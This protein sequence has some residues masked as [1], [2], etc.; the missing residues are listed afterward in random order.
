MLCEKVFECYVR[1]N[2]STR[3]RITKGACVQHH[4]HPRGACA[5]DATKMLQ[6]CYKG[7]TRVLQGCYKNVTRCYKVDHLLDTDFVVAIHLQEHLTHELLY[8]RLIHLLLQCL[9]SGVGRQQ[10]QR[11]V[12]SFV[13]TDQRV[14]ARTYFRKTETRTNHVHL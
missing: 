2:A 9:Y 7:V 1:V 13:C 5:A 6:G 4:K 10:A 8:C 11:V 3:M 12:C 14:R